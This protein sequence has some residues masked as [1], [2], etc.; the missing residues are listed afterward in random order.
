MTNTSADVLWSGLCASVDETM[1]LGRTLAGHLRGGDLIALVG[2]LGAGKTCLVRGL[3]CGMG[4]DESIVSSPTFVLEHE[5]DN[6]SGGPLLVHIDAYRISDE[7]DLATIGWEPG[8]GELA[9]HAVVAVEW[10]DRISDQLG[11]RYLQVQLEHHCQGT[12]H[13][14][15]TSLGFWTDRMAALESDLTKWASKATVPDL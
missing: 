9:V 10:A 2:D 1:A 8:G 4:I 6:P 3:A 7:A 11:P 15:V 14:V 12:R 13:A 5:Y